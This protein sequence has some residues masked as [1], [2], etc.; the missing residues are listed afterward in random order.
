MGVGLRRKGF[1]ARFVFEATSCT[2]YEESFATQFVS[3]HFVVSSQKARTE[4]DTEMNPP[5][6][7]PVIIY[8]VYHQCDSVRYIH[9]HP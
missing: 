1:G 5:T 7:V 2:R 9:S 4:G 8:L 6:H 3:N